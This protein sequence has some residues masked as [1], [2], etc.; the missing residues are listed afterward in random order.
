MGLIPA[1]M[2]LCIPFF[3]SDLAW[4]LLYLLLTPSPLV[5]V[6]PRGYLKL[7]VAL[8]TTT[9]SSHPTFSPTS[10]LAFSRTQGRKFKCWGSLISY[11]SLDIEQDP[12]AQ[13]YT[14]DEKFDLIHAAKVLHATHNIDTTV[15]QVHRL[16][17]NGGKLV[18]VEATAKQQMRGALVFG[19]LPGWC[20][21]TQISIAT[22]FL[23]FILTLTRGQLRANRQSSS[24]RRTMCIAAE[25]QWILRTGH[26]HSRYFRT[27][28]VYVVDDDVHQEEQQR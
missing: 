24:L 4:E 20:L 12:K 14:E 16:L 13:G 18:L 26:L 2:A 8:T 28:D 9:L 25:T 7:L 5:E 17:K 1:K 6:L 27:R 15:S 23:F 3:A 22:Y 11:K 19:L 10:R 21:G